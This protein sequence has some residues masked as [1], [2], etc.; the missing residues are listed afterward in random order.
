MIGVHTPEF[1]FEKDINNVR[2]AAKS[3]TIDY[4]IAVDSDYAIWRAF[5]DNY[6]PALYS[7]DP[8]GRIR[9]HHS[10]ESKYDQS[11]RIIQQLLADT[12]TDV[13]RELV[14]RSR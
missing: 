13:G 3:M 8:N 14:T 1:V 4:P 10:G 12:G 11:E 7:V 9:H 6:W 5:N 2:R